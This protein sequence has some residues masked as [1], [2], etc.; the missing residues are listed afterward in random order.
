MAERQLRSQSVDK[1]VEIIRLSGLIPARVGPYIVGVADRSAY[2]SPRA[3]AAYMRENAGTPNLML[4]TTGRDGVFNP[5]Q[6]REEILGRADRIESERKRI[7]PLG[8]P[9]TATPRRTGER[10]MLRALSFEFRLDDSRLS[11]VSDEVNRNLEAIL[12][13]DASPEVQ[14][15]LGFEGLL[16]RYG[17]R[18][19]GHLSISIDLEAVRAAGHQ[20]DERAIERDLRSN[21]TAVLSHFAGIAPQAVRITQSEGTAW[22]ERLPGEELTLAEFTEFVVLLDTARKFAEERLGNEAGS[23]APGVLTGRAERF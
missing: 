4:F 3:L 10:H 12:S 18:K 8:S 23:L 15:L 22:S 14:R 21:P 6:A 2:E 19:A 20:V 13:R 17:F 5:V 16:E 7:Q 11:A 9:R 1:A